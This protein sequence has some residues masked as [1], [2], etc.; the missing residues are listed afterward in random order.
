MIWLRA[1]DVLWQVLERFLAE[2]LAGPRSACD[3]CILRGLTFRLPS[4][5]ETF[6]ARSVLI[7]VRM[8]RGVVMRLHKIANS[9]TQPVPLVHG[10]KIA[11]AQ[12]T[13]EVSR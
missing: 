13:E 4:L 5:A 9:S 10:R 11:Q 2:G 1:L 6:H 3:D 8:R 7:V 12:A